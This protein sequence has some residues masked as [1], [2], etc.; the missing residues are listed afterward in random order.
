MEQ[1]PRCSSNL[2]K[3]AD[4]LICNCGWT[5]SKKESASQVSVV[6]SMI[7][8]FILVAGLL[9]HFLNWGSHG[10]HI[11]FANSSDKVSIC[12]DLKKYD[13]VEDSYTSLFQ[14]T[15]DLSVLEKLGELQFKRGHF[16]EAGKTYQ[17]YFS[18]NGTSYK[19]AYYYAHSLAKTGDIES[20]IK[21]F[22]SIM[23]S[24]PH[25]LMVTVVESYLEI[26]VSHNRIRKAKA[27]LSWVTKASHGTVTT[28]DQI[29]AWRKKFKI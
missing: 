4:T 10:L 29:H 12:M 15:G 13:C 5:Y 8:A 23:Q 1:C 17:L 21:Y 9:F 14:A 6:L 22:D 28:M 27:I 16:E 7:L 2:K 19:S 24:K 25:V 26:L 18:K 11:L 3:V 20:A